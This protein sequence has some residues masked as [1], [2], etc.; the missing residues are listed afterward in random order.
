MTFSVYHQA[1]SCL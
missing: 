1:H